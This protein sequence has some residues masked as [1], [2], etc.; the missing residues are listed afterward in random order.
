MTTASNIDNTIALAKWHNATMPKLRAG[1]ATKFRGNVGVAL[2]AEDVTVI[3]DR[4]FVLKGQ[5]LVVQDVPPNYLDGLMGDRTPSATVARIL[6]F[7]AGVVGGINATES[8]FPLRGMPAAQCAADDAASFT[9]AVAVDVAMTTAAC[10]AGRRSWADMA[11]VVRG[12]L[13]KI[14]LILQQDSVLLNPFVG[15]FAA[16]RDIKSPI[17]TAMSDGSVAYEVTH[18]LGE[19]QVDNF[20]EE[21]QAFVLTP[22]PT[23]ERWDS[24]EWVEYPHGLKISL[25]FPPDM[26]A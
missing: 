26:L 2:L 25:A 19:G 1:V 20:L 15:A 9:A 13:R 21:A 4:H 22:L 16:L 5:W 11:L 6:P 7:G 14:D 12:Q 18:L 23:G 10:A 17:P 24:K 3:E 8:V